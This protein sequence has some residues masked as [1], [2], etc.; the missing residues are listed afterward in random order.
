M[1][2]STDALVDLAVMCEE[3]QGVPQDLPYAARLY[4]RA[5]VKVR[6]TVVFCYCVVITFVFSLCVSRVARVAA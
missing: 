4:S 1:Q 6:I 3:G 5:V 2:G